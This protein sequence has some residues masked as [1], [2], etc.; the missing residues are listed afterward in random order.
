[1]GLSI[2]TKEYALRYEKYLPVLKGYNN[3][4]WIA[5]FEKLKSTSGYIFTF[6]G[7]AVS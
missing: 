2:N 5:D 6:E 1:M 4:N 3:T 7:A